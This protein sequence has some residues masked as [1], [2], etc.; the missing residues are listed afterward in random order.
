MASIAALFFFVGL[1]G[2][3]VHSAFLPGIGC[4][5]LSA[6]YY[7]QSSLRLHQIRNHEFI[8]IV[9]YLVRLRRDPRELLPLGLPASWTIHARSAR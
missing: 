9:D 5:C 7:L 8:S 2:V 6:V 3:L 4:S 1:Y